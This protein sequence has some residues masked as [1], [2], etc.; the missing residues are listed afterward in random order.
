MDAL[1]DIRIKLQ[2]EHSNNIRED[3][4]FNIKNLEDLIFHSES[5]AAIP[6]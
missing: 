3:K 5:R 6:A 4:S 2:K 1:D